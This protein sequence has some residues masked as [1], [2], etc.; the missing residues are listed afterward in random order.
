MSRTI[1]FLLGAPPTARRV[2]TFASR[3]DLGIAHV[4]QVWKD[5]GFSWHYYNGQ[6][7]GSYL[8]QPS[9]EQTIINSEKQYYLKESEITGS[10]ADWPTDRPWFLRNDRLV[11]SAVPRPAQYDTV[12][13]GV[14][15]GFE[16]ISSTATS[17]TVYGQN[18]YDRRVYDSRHGVDRYLT[19]NHALRVKVAGSIFDVTSISN[20]T[21]DPDDVGPTTSWNANQAM[22][23]GDRFF[24]QQNSDNA[25]RLYE[26]TSS[27]AAGSVW[28]ASEEAR[29]TNLRARGEYTINVSG[30]ISTAPN[31]GDFVNVLRQQKYVSGCATTRGTFCQKYGS[32]E[33]K[34]KLPKGAGTFAAA[35]LWRNFLEFAGTN[36]TARDK[37][38]EFDL[39]EA[40]GHATDIVYHNLHAPENSPGGHQGYFAGETPLDHSNA[41]PQSA[42]WT[43]QNI[44]QHQVLQEPTDSDYYDPGAEFVTVRFDWYQPEDENVPYG[45]ATVEGEIGNTCAYYVKL[46]AWAEP[47]LVAKSYLGPDSFDGVIDHAMLQ[48]NMAM[49]GN[50]NYDQEINDATYPRTIGALPAPWEMEIEYFDVYQFE[51]GEAGFAGLPGVDGSYA[52]NT[53]PTPGDTTG[54]SGSGIIPVLGEVAA[55][56]LGNQILVKGSVV[57]F[58]Q[59]VP[60]GYNAED[61]T[62]NWTHTLGTRATFL[63]LDTNKEEVTL[64]IVED[65]AL[66]S[67]DYV[68]CDVPEL[69]EL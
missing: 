45:P 62:F 19:D 67:S 55:Q 27:S 64:K 26:V 12:A 34:L 54:N 20:D 42:G 51:G 63:D 35:W 3:F 29:Y 47:R 56:I 52:D 32:F 68:R 31:A 28:N 36:W 43:N 60:A 21:V 66:T 58:R 33:I 6:S 50:F 18:Y 14:V 40:L 9:G 5:R 48:L 30:T 65:V 38:I 13:Y 11:L 22:N 25:W 61:L 69:P 57:R 59:Q 10:V 24:Q 4:N 1:N 46:D 8:E 37:D 53:T 16:V 23:A 39:I 49:E 41:S 17:I 44:Q 2:K 7:D 15:Q